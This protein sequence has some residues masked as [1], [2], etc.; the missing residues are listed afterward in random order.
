MSLRKLFALRRLVED[1]P[2]AAITEL[3]LLVIIKRTSAAAGSS[4]FQVYFSYARRVFKGL[5]LSSSAPAKTNP[6]VT[7]A[8][9][10]KPCSG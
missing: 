2:I 9:K 5:G 10:V 8:N 4:F 3:N 6:L 1:T 7:A